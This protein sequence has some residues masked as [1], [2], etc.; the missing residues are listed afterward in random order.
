[1]K[2]LEKLREGAPNASKRLRYYDG[3][4]NRTNAMICSARHG[5]GGRGPYERCT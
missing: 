1:M 4:D 5:G 3:K 2:Q